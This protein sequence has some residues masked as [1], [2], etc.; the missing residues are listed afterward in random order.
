MQN[1]AVQNKVK[2]FSTF[3]ESIQLDKFFQILGQDADKVCYGI[4]S[5]EFSLDSQAIE[6]LLI[7]DKLFRSKN[8]G[9]R[10][11][12]VGLV[13]RAEKGGVKTIIFSST[14]PSGERLENLS[15]VA[16]MLRYPLPGLEDIEEEDISFEEY[17]Q[18]NL[19]EEVKDEEFRKPKMTFDEQQLQL[20]LQESG[21]D[22]VGAEEDEY[23]ENESSKPQ[24]K[25]HEESSFM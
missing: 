2:D 21:G 13:E 9:T 5:V 22:D 12:Y 11:Q 8:V 6:V 16:A 18:Q 14:N 17:D 20:L 7:S 19:E 4:K 3:Q 10:K 24:T 25:D 15:G 1:Q 23:Q